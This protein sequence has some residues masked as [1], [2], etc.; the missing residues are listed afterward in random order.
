LQ[1]RIQSISVINGCSIK[2]AMNAP[3][4]PSSVAR[5]KPVGLLAPGTGW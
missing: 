3:A 4:T 2:L 5:M 1:E